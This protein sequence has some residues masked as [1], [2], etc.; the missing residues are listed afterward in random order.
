MPQQPSGR[1]EEAVLSAWEKPVVASSATVPTIAGFVLTRSALHRVE[2]RCDDGR[3]LFEFSTQTSRITSVVMQSGWAGSHSLQRLGDSD[4]W[5]IVLPNAREHFG[6]PG[7]H[8]ALQR[9]TDDGTVF[10]ITY[11]GGEAEEFAIANFHGPLHLGRGE[12]S[13]HAESRTR[14]RS[15]A[16][17]SRGLRP[18]SAARVMTAE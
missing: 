12:G 8:G 15:P 1:R 3:W 2:Y 6:A 5:V 13:D 11:E 18:R 17:H 9:L 7:C 14:R 10:T 16:V 4:D